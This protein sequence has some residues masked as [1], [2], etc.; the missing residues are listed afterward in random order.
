MHS[1]KETSEQ[2]KV[3]PACVDI[4]YSA[5]AVIDPNIQPRVV[6]LK[7]FTESLICVSRFMALRDGDSVVIL[8]S[9]LSD[10]EPTVFW[11]LKRR[12][13]V[14]VFLLEEP[15]EEMYSLENCKLM[16]GSFVEVKSTRATVRRFVKEDFVD[17]VF[18]LTNGL[19]VTCLLLHV[20]SRE[21]LP[22]EAEIVRLALQ[23]MAPFGTIV[24]HGWAPS[25]VDPAECT[26][27]LEKSGTMACFNPSTFAF[28]ESHHG[29]WLHAVVE[30]LGLH[31]IE[32]I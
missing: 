8:A 25:Q 6:C 21:L 11:S 26:L 12:A 14:F 2:L 22:T 3:F 1:V 13:S 31:K 23:I 15:S 5:L 27:L 32:N 16:N 10:I 19:G 24:F 20:T 9:I 18:G 28:S 4:A 17:V 29:L 7:A 30:V